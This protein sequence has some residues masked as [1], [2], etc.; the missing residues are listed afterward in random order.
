MNGE[1][2]L[3]LGRDPDTDRYEIRMEMD[4]STKQVKVANFRV[5][6]AARQ[7]YA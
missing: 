5:L 7:P 2:A 4:G 6:A 1:R 3:I